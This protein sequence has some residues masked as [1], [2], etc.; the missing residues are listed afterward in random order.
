LHGTNANGSCDDWFLTNPSHLLRSCP[1]DCDSRSSGSGLD[2]VFPRS[3]SARSSPAHLRQP[4]LSRAAESRQSPCANDRWCVSLRDR[5]YRRQADTGW[6]F[7]GDRSHRTS[8]CRIG[9]STASVLD[10]SKTDGRLLVMLRKGSS[11]EQP[12]WVLPTSG[13]AALRV[14]NI[15][16]HAAAWMP[17]GISVLYAI[18]NDLWTVRLTDGVSTRLLTLPGSAFWPRWSPDGS[19]LRFTLVDPNTHASSIWEMRNGSKLLSR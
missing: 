5:S 12:L 17:D 16:A 3:T 18:G 15:M 13:G 14:A 7:H 2:D 4:Y 1:G 10:I 6:N 9:F 8:G 11:V 19:L